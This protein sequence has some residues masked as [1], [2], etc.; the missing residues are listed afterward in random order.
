M[1]IG[2]LPDYPVWT[3]QANLCRHFH[4]YQTSD[5]TTKANISFFRFSANNDPVCRYTDYQGGFIM[6]PYMS[7]PPQN[8]IM[9]YNSWEFS[10]CTTVSVCNAVEK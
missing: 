1:N 6:Q 8:P 3:A 7:V 4:M 5:S 10:S 9:W 2:D